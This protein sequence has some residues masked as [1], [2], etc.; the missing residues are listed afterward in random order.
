MPEAGDGGRVNGCRA[1]RE[2]MSALLD[3]AATSAEKAALDAHLE[4]CAECREELEEL[5]FTT[6]QIRSLE[7]VEPPPWMTARI[8]AR[9]REAEAPPVPFWRRY[10]VPVLASAQFRVATLVLVG[11]AGYYIV[12]KS[13]GVPRD[14][15]DA[16]PAPDTGRSAMEDAPRGA[17]APVEK[18][19]FAPAPPG[20]SRTAPGIEKKDARPA[21]SAGRAQPAPPRREA[22]APL[23]TRADS[24]AEKP[25]PSVAVLAGQEADAPA[26]A[27]AAP[28][29][30]AAPAATIAG[31]TRSAASALNAEAKQKAASGPSPAARQAAEA[32]PRA[33]LE[34][35]PFAAGKAAGTLGARDSGKLEKGAPPPAPVLLVRIEPFD[36]AAFPALLGE[37][38][39]RSG[40]EVAGMPGKTAANSLTATLDSRRLPGL[41]DRLALAGTVRERPRT[42]GP[43]SVITLTIRW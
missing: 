7:P 14:L 11:A 4:G 43:P 21:P 34:E 12:S 8:M 13:G 26:V 35:V 40:A 30:L 36:P 20:V 41:L 39:R 28:A 29:A 38:L 23:E 42:E 6:R 3:G 32:A 17:P 24:L 27:P 15:P 5:R 9:L 37:E 18:E 16:S 1:H 22:Q 31:S 25:A 19:P 10:F 2:T 33:H